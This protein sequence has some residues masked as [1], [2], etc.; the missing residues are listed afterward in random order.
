MTRHRIRLIL[1]ILI[2]TWISTLWLERSFFDESAQWMALSVRR[3]PLFAVTLLIYAAFIN[4]IPKKLRQQQYDSRSLLAHLTELY[5]R[6]TLVQLWLGYRLES[7]YAQT[8]LGILWVILLPLLTSLVL[9]FAFTQFVG[10]SGVVDNVPY[11]AFLLA[12]LS[13]FDVGHSIILRA[14][15]SLKGSMHIISR[16]YF[17]REIVLLVMV[18]EVLVDFCVTFVAMVV[19]NALFFQIYPNIYYVF[20]PL[21]VLIM[22]AFSLGVAFIVAWYGLLIND[23]QP[24]LTIIMQLLFYL[25]VLFS[26]SSA[27]SLAIILLNVNPL[28]LLLEAFRDIVLF[29]RPPNGLNLAFA[30]CLA[31]TLLYVGYT[32]FKVNENRFVEVA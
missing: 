15:E 12:G 23:L 6:R 27:S 17:P 28:A 19:I 18:G 4:N 29:A 5:S 24:L 16:V 10:Y 25:T 7:R 8:I 11:V 26:R 3:V 30:A 22:V 32:L 9:A 14:Q 20:L 31:I 13:I 1:F 2:S 21:I